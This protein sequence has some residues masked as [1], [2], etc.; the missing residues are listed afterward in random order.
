[1][2]FKLDKEL[3]LKNENLKIIL[4]GH[5][6]QSNPNGR[7]N[8]S[9]LVKIPAIDKTFK[10]DEELIDLLFS[11]IPNDIPQVSQIMNEE[12]APK[13]GKKARY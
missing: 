9:F 13:R 4:R 3:F 12:E 5:Y 6:T 7:D 8:A 11:D 1:M 2:E 10:I